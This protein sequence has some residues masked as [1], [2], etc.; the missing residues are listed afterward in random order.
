MKAAQASSQGRCTAGTWRAPG[1][2]RGR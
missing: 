1:R 2:G